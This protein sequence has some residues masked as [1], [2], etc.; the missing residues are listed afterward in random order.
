MK[1]RCEMDGDQMLVLSSAH[2]DAFGKALKR[3]GRLDA[4]VESYCRDASQFL[5]F[6]QQNQ[7]PIGNVAP[8]TLQQ[9]G[10]WLQYE[11]LERRNSI[12]RSMIGVRQFF[13]FLSESGSIVGSP[14]DDVAIPSRDDT[15]GW[16]LDDEEVDLIFEAADAGHPTIKRL[17]DKALLCLLAF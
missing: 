7:L 6:L 11:K 2:I 17:R 15:L 12:R 9:F 4:T 14:F 10:E 16:R 8:E 1:F 3:H 5:I 13:R